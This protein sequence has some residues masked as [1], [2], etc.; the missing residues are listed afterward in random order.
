MPFMASPP[1]VRH[2]IDLLRQS[3]MCTPDVTV[4]T[5]EEEL[6]GVRGFGTEHVCRD[7]D[8]LKT[9]MEKW[10]GWR[11]DDRVKGKTGHEH[12]GHRASA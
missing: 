3:L 1:H 9:W 7:W 5:K 10:E 4:E 11:Q 6:G 12:A 2:C 8:E